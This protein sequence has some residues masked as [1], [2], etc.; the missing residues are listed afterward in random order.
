[1][2][3]GF[4]KAAA[5]TPKVTVADCEANAKEILACIRGMSAR[6]AAVMVFPELCLTGYTCGDLFW[7]ETLLDDALR[8]LQLICEETKET[9]GLLFIGMPFAFSGKLYNT[10]VVLNRGSILGIVPKTHLPNYDEFYERR[11]FTPAPEEVSFA[12]LLGCE[13]PFGT[14]LLFSCDSVPELTVAAEICED[15]WVPVPP[16]CSHAM[17]GATVI[18]NLSASDEMVGKE[19]YR[20]QL[21]RTHSASAVCGYVYAAAGEGESTTDLVFGGQNFIAEDGRLLAES[22]RF[23][24]GILY[25]DLDV[26]RILAERRRIS[27][28]P[29]A[30][31]FDDAYYRVTFEL[32]KRETELERVFDPHPFVPDDAAEREKRCEEIFM[33]QAMGL[34]KRLEHIRAQ[35]A[36]LGISG[37]LDS[38]LALLVTAKAFDLLG[39]P[40][41]RIL[42]I[43]M[44]GFGTTDR[45]YD[46]ACQLTRSLGAE[47]R[48]IP[49]REAVTVHFSDIGHDMNVHDVTYENAQARER[50]QILMDVANQEGALVVDTGDL[51]ELALGWAT[52]NGDHMSMYGVNGSI[53]KTLVRHLVAYYADSCGDELIARVL[54]DVLDT[55]VSPELLPPEGGVISQKTEELVGP[56]ELHDFFLYYMLRA[57]FG[58]KKILRIAERSFAGSYSR[59]EILKWLKKFCSRF[60]SQQFKPIKLQDKKFAPLT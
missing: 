58:P 37:G 35:R 9:D 46:N 26:K 21:V 27:T 18:V 6:G 49:I 25:A 5:A 42:A 36:V 23:E 38:T 15:L 39:L 41:E 28:W 30:A 1:M 50:T 33:I 13:V 52:F 8:Q 43:T 60:F 48:E 4:I 24:N 31:G 47:L 14:Q 32:E 19:S 20:R 10:A 16:S 55:P 45:T 40:R 22:R 57:G 34:K 29:A 11:N 54:R 56:Y 7:Q 12:E 17:A 44:P 53:P 3:D 51:S 59:E 2:K